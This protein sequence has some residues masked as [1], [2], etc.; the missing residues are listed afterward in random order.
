MPGD[1]SR[2]ADLMERARRVIPGGMYGHQ[3]TARLPVSFP[4]FFSRAEGTRLWDADGREFIDYMCGYGPNLFGYGFAKV[5]AAADAQRALGDSMTGPGPVMVELAEAMVD[6]VTHADWAMFCKNGTDAT[7]MALLVARAHRDRRK[8]VLA[9]DTYHGAAAWSTP[10]PGGVLPEDRA[11]LIYCRYNDAQSLED[12]V[13]EAGDDLAGICV[14]PFRH[15][16]FRHQH[17]PELEFARL[18]RELCDRHD[19]L[20][21]LDE[22]RAGFRLARDCSWHELGVEPDLS[23]WGKA[24]ANGHPL[25]ALLGSER[26]RE[27]AQK[28]YLTGSFWFSAVPMAAAVATLKEIRESD[29]LE[30]T[31]RTGTALRDG[32]Q[33]QAA[34][35]GFTLRQTGPVQMPQIFFEEDEDFRLGYAW[36]EGALKRGIY[37]HPFHNMF[38]CAALTD[39]DVRETLEKTDLA[40]AELRRAAPGLQGP[41]SQIAATVAAMAGDRR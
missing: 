11:H 41:P 40:F 34:S 31:L 1:M 9:R 30:R 35:H 22:V 32:L 18:A 12:A 25:S 10:R 8:I 14:T 5:E 6:T 33:Q 38:I 21:I 39:A 37:L 28:P 7:S 15:E 20:L 26:A 36:V 19:A 3:S 2:H 24:I 27:A 4:Q 17:L 29:Y 16:T 13:R 23:C